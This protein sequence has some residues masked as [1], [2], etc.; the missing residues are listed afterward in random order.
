MTTLPMLIIQRMQWASD[1][2]LWEASEVYLSAVQI[3]LE[4]IPE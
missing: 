3:Q 1:C 2:K 4:L